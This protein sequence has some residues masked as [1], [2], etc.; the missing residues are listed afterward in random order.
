[1]TANGAKRK[2]VV[3]PERSLVVADIGRKTLTFASQFR[4]EDFVRSSISVSLSQNLGV[5][6]Q[7]EAHLSIRRSLRNCEKLG[8]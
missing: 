4:D 3:G 6:R 1:M 5:V 2:T 7:T 8:E